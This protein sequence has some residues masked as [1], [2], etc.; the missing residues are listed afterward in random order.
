MHCTQRTRCMFS[1]VGTISSVGLPQILT[2]VHIWIWKSVYDTIFQ[3][4]LQ[5]CGGFDRWPVVHVRISHVPVLSFAKCY[6]VISAARIGNV[7]V[8]VKDAFSTLMSC[9]D[10]YAS[11]SYE[12]TR[13]SFLV[14][15]TFYILHTSIFWKY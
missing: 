6:I 4:F 15:L 10:N 1:F 3:L 11:Y 9:S 7:V 13:W 8:S 12:A 14:E 5:L 2:D